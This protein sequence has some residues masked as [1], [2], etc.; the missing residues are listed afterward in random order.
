[1]KRERVI[2][3]CAISLLLGAVTGIYWHSQIVKRTVEQMKRDAKTSV[4]TE[5]ELPAADS[6][7][8]NI[9]RLRNVTS[10]RVAYMRAKC[11]G[12]K[13]G[14]RLEMEYRIVIDGLKLGVTAAK[15]EGFRKWQII[16]MCLGICEGVAV[17]IYADPKLDD[18]QMRD[19]RAGLRQK[20]EEDENEIT[21]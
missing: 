12:S 14:R 8:R 10:H 7:R 2:L 6:P 4:H 17:E 1:M 5:K 11:Q 9:R 19:I 20:K 16:E 3:A 18:D 15:E 13:R 21:N